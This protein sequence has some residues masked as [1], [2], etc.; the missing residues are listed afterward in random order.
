MEKAKESNNLKS[1]N[2]RNSTLD[3]D[4]NNDPL[5]LSLSSSVDDPL[6]LSLSSSYYRN[7]RP[8]SI[9]TP[10]ANSEHGQQHIQMQTLLQSQTSPLQLPSNCPHIPMFVPP[11]S[12]IRLDPL[13]AAAP[14]APVPA[15]S[16]SPP[17]PPI[18]DPSEGPSQDDENDKII[19]PPFPWATDRPAR[20]HTLQ[21]LMQNKILIINGDVQCGSCH[22][23]FKMGFDLRQKFGEL[24]RFIKQRKSTMHERAPDEWK[25]P[26]LPTCKHCGQ[27][28]SVK[29]VI[30]D[31]KEHSINWLFLLLGQL[32]GLCTLEHLRY[33]CMH[34]KHHRTAAKDRLLYLTYFQL[35]KQ[36]LPNG[37]I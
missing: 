21:Y 26:I 1:E 28:N 33:F 19:P 10:P 32:L 11:P 35:C 36:L 25:N 24:C 18:I 37:V 16:P 12:I 3:H 31:E 8:R 22:R 14:P 20:V 17:P 29:P 15:H 13:P 5:S 7:V 23:K 2:K 34:T 27:E 4:V 30:G 6:A 9:I